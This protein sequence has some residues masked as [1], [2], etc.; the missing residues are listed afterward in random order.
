MASGLTMKTRLF[1]LV[2]A[3][4]LAAPVAVAGSKL[5]PVIRVYLKKSNAQQK[6]LLLTSRELA[7][8][9]YKP[10]CGEF[11]SIRLI[12]KRQ[13]VRR[14]SAS[15]RNKTADLAVLLDGRPVATQSLR[16]GKS[17]G[18]LQLSGPFTE[19]EASGIVRRILADRRP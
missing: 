18:M 16:H 8:A 5:N 17:P 2:A 3:L 11:C 10:G 7:G 12:L 1:G 14:L 9:S 15:S 13:S 4:F 19:Y 6:K